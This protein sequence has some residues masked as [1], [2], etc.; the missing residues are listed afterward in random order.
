MLVAQS[1]LTLC[2]PVNCS[3]PGSSIPGILQVRILEWTV[4]SFLTLKVRKWDPCSRSSSKRVR[5]EPI[6][7]LS[8][9]LFRFLWLRWVS[10]VAPVIKNTPAIAGDVRDTGSEMEGLNPPA[11]PWRRA[12]QLTPVFLLENPMDREAWPATVYGVAKSWTGLK[13][14]NMH[15][16]DSYK[17]GPRPAASVP[18]GNSFRCNSSDPTLDLQNQTTEGWDQAPGAFKS[19]PSDSRTHSSLRTTDGICT[20]SQHFYKLQG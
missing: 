5:A 17:Y 12:W 10:Q 7:E 20:N 19:L 16:H 8:V 14:P 9:S 4:M 13:R 6:K 18:P 15:T 1:C 2:D 3:L 11:I